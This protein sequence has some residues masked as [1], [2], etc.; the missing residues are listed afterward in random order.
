MSGTER[1]PCPGS[2]CRA[3]PERC[4][5]RQSD[6]HAEAAAKPNRYGQAYHAAHGRAH[7]YAR[8]ANS[9]AHHRTGRLSDFATDRQDRTD[10]RYGCAYGRSHGRRS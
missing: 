8:A 7:G 3:L 2:S 9:C 5:G 10:F 1:L 4:V 6:A